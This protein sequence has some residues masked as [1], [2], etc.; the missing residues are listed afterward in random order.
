MTVKSSSPEVV[1]D[2][3]H[4]PQLA[5][6]LLGRHERLAADVAAALG[7]DL[8]LEVRRGDAGRD[9]QLGLALDVEDVPV[10]GVHVDRRR[11][12]SRG[13]AAAMPF[14]R[15]RRRPGS[16]GTC[17]ARLTVRRAPSAISGPAVQVHVGGAEVA[18][19][20][21][22]AAEVDGLVAV[23]HHEL[24]AHRVVHAGPEQVRLG[25]QQLA[26][27]RG[28]MGPARGRDLEAVGQER[29][30]A[31]GP[32]GRAAGTSA[33]APARRSEW[34]S[35]RSPSVV[36]VVGARSPRRRGSVHSPGVVRGR[37][38]ARARAA[39]PDGLDDQPARRR[40]DDAH[41]R[42]SPGRR[43]RRMESMVIRVGTGALHR[44]PPRRCRVASR[45]DTHGGSAVPSSPIDAL[46]HVINQGYG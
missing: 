6:H 30:R 36:R 8:V 16:A 35:W 18:D 10:A 15:D 11:A 9:E 34:R 25:P 32:G 42:R 24:G 33:R 17:A 37:R 29:G 7:Q 22:V 4:H 26:E 31:R 20:E 23:V 12:G 27:A 14:V 2:G 44:R 3:P 41:D 19:R 1:G 43:C 46:M 5:D 39:R 40:R 38:E 45:P 21:R 13:A 28:R